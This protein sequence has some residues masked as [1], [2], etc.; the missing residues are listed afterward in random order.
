[1]PIMVISTVKRIPKSGRNKINRSAMNQQ[2]RNDTHT[3]E[4]AKT[5]HSVMGRSNA[6]ILIHKE[7]ARIKD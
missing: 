2:K 7:G 1:M 4:N 5:N 6:Q 3:Q